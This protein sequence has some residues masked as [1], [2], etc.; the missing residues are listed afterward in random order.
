MHAYKYVCA[1]RVYV[2]RLKSNG[3]LFLYATL[4]HP[5]ALRMEVSVYVHVYRY[6]CGMCVCMLLDPKRMDVNPFIN[7]HTHI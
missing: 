6:L 2:S 1:V 5:N 7:I 3:Y 4:E